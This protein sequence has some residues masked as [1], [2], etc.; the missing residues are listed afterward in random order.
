LGRFEV[1]G[2]IKNRGGKG[3]S[4]TTKPGTHKEYRATRIR[5]RA[6]TILNWRENC[7]ALGEK[8]TKDKS[9]SVSCP[10]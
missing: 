9:C 2:K 7:H 8:G 4:D 10:E 1:S 3:T 5:G 6:L